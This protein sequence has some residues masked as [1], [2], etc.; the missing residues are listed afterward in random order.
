MFFNFCRSLF[1]QIKLLEN[2]LILLLGPG[3]VDLWNEVTP[4]VSSQKFFFVFHP[5]NS[6]LCLSCHASV[7]LKICAPSLSNTTNIP[8]LLA[9][10]IGDCHTGDVFYIIKLQNNNGFLKTICSPQLF[11][12]NILT[13]HKHPAFSINHSSG[14]D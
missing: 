2:A 13:L 4:N 11:S 10:V 14:F 9:R 7:Q 3:L 12:T 8:I 1:L 5:G 6:C